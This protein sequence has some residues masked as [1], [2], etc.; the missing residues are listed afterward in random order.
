MEI[1]IK[2]KGDYHKLFQTILNPPKSNFVT[3]H[4][5][6]A[7]L[8]P[9]DILILTEFIIFQLNTQIEVNL[10]VWSPP[11]K[12]HLLAIGL[13]E[14]C[15]KNHRSSTQIIEIQKYTAMPICRV[16]RENMNNYIIKTQSFFQ[17]FLYEKDLDVLGIVLSEMI[18]NVYDHSSSPIGC[19]VFCQYYPQTKLIMISV[20]D[21]G[22]GI[23]ITVNK[24]LNSIGKEPLSS[25]DAV[26]WAIE[27]NRTTKSM[28]YN[29]GK[30]LDTIS[31]FVK[32]N[33]GSWRIYSDIVTMISKNGEVQYSVNPIENFTGTVIEVSI[34]V[35][36]LNTKE[37]VDFFEW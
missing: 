3:I 32:S 13:F 23:P 6:Q 4:L 2:S 25:Q 12:N 21:L 29:A 30:G 15:S 14:F 7:F 31:T 28:P 35:D 17:T 26:K 9:M 22:F 5:Y 24:F 37:T 33:N 20:A 8:F 1:V 36:N 10:L 27:L 19:Y 34:K 16:S 11:V 18:N